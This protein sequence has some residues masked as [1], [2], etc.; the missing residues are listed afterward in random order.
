MNII[1]ILG[2]TATAAV[3][4]SFVFKDMVKLRLVNATGALLWLLYAI[5]KSDMPLVGVNV[6]VLSIHLLW[7]ITNKLKWKS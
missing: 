2:W 5:M 6:A 4:L 3:L 7:F 1:D